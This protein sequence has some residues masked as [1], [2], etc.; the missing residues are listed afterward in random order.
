MRCS[1]ILPAVLCLI[2]PAV[3]TRA[4]LVT[5]ELTGE[6]TFVDES[7]ILQGLFHIGDPVTGIYTYDAD[8]G[9]KNPWGSV[10]DY[11]FNTE[12]Y[13]VVLDLSGL[14]IQTDPNNVH[15]SIGILNNMNGRDSY[16]FSSDVNL[17]LPNGLPVRHISWQLDD[18]SATALSSDHLPTEAPV[19]EDWQ[20]AGSL[21]I[22]FGFKGGSVIGAGIESATVVPEPS[23][24]CILAVLSVL[25]IGRQR[26]RRYEG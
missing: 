6:V 24:F 17:P 21:N 23:T 5:I 11:D 20:R 4:E 2:L 3:R 12:P 16:G 25:T 19:L 8:M 22:E 18:W 14:T 7:P 9:D 13:G 10:G 1:A 26:A 15:F